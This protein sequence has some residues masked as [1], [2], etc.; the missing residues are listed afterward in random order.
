M[1]TPHIS[2]LPKAMTSIPHW[3]GWRQEAREGSTKPTKVPYNITTGRRAR[4]NAPEDWCAF[5]EIVPEKYSGIGFMFS[6][7]IGMTGIDLDDCI[8]AD[9]TYK[10]W[11]RKILAVFKNT[12]SEISPSGTGIKIFTL[13]LLPG[14]GR[15]VFVNADGNPCG[16]AESDGA[17]EMYDSG[18][19]FAVTGRA[20][21]PL[22]V[23][24]CY[25]Q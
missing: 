18:R 16:E 21:G 22:E 24:T 19:Y 12:Y 25:W 9:G 13:G 4:S 14:K 1:P 20:T 2:A 17:V 7:D 15:K 6:K 3:V 8:L 10:P 11:A 5:P 23:T